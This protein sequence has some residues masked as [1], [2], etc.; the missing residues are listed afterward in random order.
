MQCVV[1]SVQCAVCTKQCA[2]P[3]RGGEISRE[4]G[5]GQGS[6]GGTL[7][8]KVRLV[9]LMNKYLEEHYWTLYNAHGYREVLMQSRANLG[10]SKMLTFSIKIFFID[11]M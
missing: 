8:S 5:S 4:V 7:R 1:C 11:S 9:Y 3:A 6:V 10:I 2:V